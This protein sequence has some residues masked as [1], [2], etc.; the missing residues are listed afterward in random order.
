MSAT[1]TAEVHETATG[2]GGILTTISSEQATFG[3]ENGKI[4]ITGIR[5]VTRRK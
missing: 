1:V 3:M 4:V 2:S 5:A